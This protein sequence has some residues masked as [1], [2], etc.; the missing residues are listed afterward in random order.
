MPEP[1]KILFIKPY[2]P[3]TNYV[4]APP[5]G[6]LYLT[7]ALRRELGDRVDIRLVDA[8][9]LRRDAV[10]LRG[11]LVWADLVGISALNHE[12]QASF[13][14]AKL[15]KAL[16]PRKLVVLG[17]PYAHGRAEEILG[18]CADLDWVVDGE[19][20]RLFPLAVAAH[21]AGRDPEGL[22]G[23][24]RRAD[25]G[26]VRPMSLDFI[27]DLDEIAVPAWDLVDFD[28]Y[29]KAPNMNAWLKG[30]RYATLFTSR[31][32][33]YKCSYCHDIFTKKFR[34]RSPENV[35]SEMALL[36]DR[37]GVDEFQIIDDIFNLHKPRVKRIFDGIE[38]R[39]GLGRFHFC[40]PNGL[41]GDILDRETIQT[42]GR[43]GAYQITV[44][45][46]TATPRLQQLIQKNLDIEKV[47]GF[48]DY[49]HEAGILVKGYFMLGFPTETEEELKATIRFALRSNLTF[50]SFFTVIPQPGTPLH[51]LAQQENPDALALIESGDYYQTKGY[52][53]TATGF[54]LARVTRWAYIRFYLGSPART[55]RLLRVLGLRK[56]LAGFS[57][58]LGLLSALLPSGLLGLRGDKSRST[59]LARAGQ[60]V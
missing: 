38:A 48:I 12:A 18:R 8:K 58:L 23:L 53:E 6:L 51:R 41:R 5:L 57:V 15:A 59:K 20:E 13:A 54:P 29:A 45:L 16:D 60:E 9:L 2:Q 52:Y 27:E 11:D 21:L 47:Q 22:P 10:S 7:A 19:S 25:D 36:A 14:I 3:V 17:G 37:Y 28:A 55:I 40:F 39:W 30:W 32:C 31:G 1:L 24:Y 42:L 33:P 4:V 26:I 50:A 44:A 35:L 56:A 49:A 34:W 46:E 43:G